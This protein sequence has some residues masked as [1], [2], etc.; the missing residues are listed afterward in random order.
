V[1]H[2]GADL[3]QLYVQPRPGGDIALA[4]GIA[5]RLFES[6]NTDPDAARYCD[7][8][9]AF[10]SLAFSR[11]ADDWAALADVRPD[12]IRDLADL[13]GDGPAAI[14]VGWGCSARRTAPRRCACSTRWARS[15]EPR[16]FRRRRLAP[17]AAGLSILARAGPPRRLLEP[18]LGR[19]ILDAEDPRSGWS[20]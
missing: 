11:G 2:R 20:G 14:L 10:R 7:H 15:A 13:Y 4:L 1:R 18:L 12:E 17:S 3:A 5:R 19:Q 9:D 8:L 16:R 6:G